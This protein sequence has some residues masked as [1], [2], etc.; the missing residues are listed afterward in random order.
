MSNLSG[1]P[2]AA[3]R[4]KNGRFSASRS[5]PIGSGDSTNH[6]EVSQ[7]PEIS[8]IPLASIGL[9]DALGSYIAIPATDSQASARRSY[10][11]TVGFQATLA[12]FSALVA[13]SPVPP[14]DDI[15]DFEVE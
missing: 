1:L 12:A 9:S 3:V 7:A 2:S 15:E 10:A 13:P 5:T 6:P 11:Q 8:A 4:S 14:F